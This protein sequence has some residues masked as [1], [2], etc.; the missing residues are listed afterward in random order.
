MSRKHLF[1]IV[2]LLGAAAVA[3]LLALTRTTTAA[4]PAASTEIAAKSHSLDQ[5][6]AS[7]RRSLAER[8]PALHRA[9]QTAHQ[10][11]PPTVLVRA[12]AASQAPTGEREDEHRDD[13]RAYEGNE[14]EPEGAD[15]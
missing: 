9:R 8:L 15:D 5:L 6:E 7:L 2:V 14:Y 12:A 10:S 4:M 13:D 1:A 3:G 11:A